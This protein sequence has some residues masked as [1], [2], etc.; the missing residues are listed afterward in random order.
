[1]VSEVP[2]LGRKPIC[3]GDFVRTLLPSCNILC[4]HP[5]HSSK[6]GIDTINTLSNLKNHFSCQ[7]ERSPRCCLFP[8][9]DKYR[10][11]SSR[12]PASGARATLACK[13]YQ[14]STRDL[15]AKMQRFKCWMN[16]IDD[17]DFAL[18]FT[19]SLEI[20]ELVLL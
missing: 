6:A 14:T 13:F 16:N 19:R 7:M 3:N 4:D 8:E 20:V 11:S 2:F 9:L 12:C 1:M 15:L 5:I 18:I 17:K 10:I